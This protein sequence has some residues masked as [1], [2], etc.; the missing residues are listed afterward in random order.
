MAASQYHVNM[1]S[2]ATARSARYGP[3]TSRNAAGVV[4]TFRCTSTWPVASRMQTYIVMLSRSR[5]TTT[6]GTML[7]S[8]ITGER[9]DFKED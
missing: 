1:H 8:E 2:A 9:Y 6:L 4:G 7:R 5:P 3:A